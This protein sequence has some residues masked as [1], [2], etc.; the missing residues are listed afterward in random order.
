MPINPGVVVSGAEPGQAL[1]VRSGVAPPVKDVLVAVAVAVLVLAEVRGQQLSPYAASIPL[2]LLSAVALAW[3]RRAAL[4]VLVVSTGALLG[5]TVAGVPLARSAYPVVTG[6]VAVYSV[7]Q[8]EPL[9]RALAGLVA[10]S[11]GM[12][13][14]IQI[15]VANGEAFGNTDRAF[16]L[17]FILAPWIFGR[18]VHVRT[19][20]IA[21]HFARAEHAER[22]QHRAVEQERARIARELH[23]VIA[24][25]LS[26]MVVQAGAGEEMAKRA[27]ERA[28][29]PLR[30]VQETGRQALA[31]MGRLLGILR[32]GGEEIGLEPQPGIDDLDA[33]VART[34]D[35]GLVVDLV[36]EG[37]PHALPLGLDLC[38]YRIVQEA[39]TNVRKHA[40]RARARVRLRHRPGALE[41]EVLDDGTGTID[42][43]GGGHG[44][45]GMRERVAI[46]G[47][48]LEAGPRPEGGFAVHATLP[49]VGGG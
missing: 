11:T 29:E 32:E 4:P 38:A 12:L 35:A 13:V 42:G 36:V 1:G 26:V 33:L 17:A 9:A 48:R 31:E 27:P 43:I 19:R 49:L 7:S 28:I 6:F 18:A 30:Q 24:H 25:S 39:L 44:L 41:I 16:V 34:R 15:A 47:G 2:G 14:C 46:F 8:F 40:G 5:Q 22:E 21:L 23:D 20:D 37:T 45:V 10:A 3:R